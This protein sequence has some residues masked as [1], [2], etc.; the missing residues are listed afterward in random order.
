[1]GKI[2]KGLRFTQ[3]TNCAMDW[4]AGF[5]MPGCPGYPDKGLYAI[6]SVEDRINTSKIK[7]AFPTPT[8]CGGITQALSDLNDGLNY[9]ISI[10]KNG[11]LLQKIN[12]KMAKSVYSGKIAEYTDFY[13]KNCINSTAAQP[14]GSADPVLQ[15]ATPSGTSS[16]SAP[17]T[18]STGNGSVVNNIT[19][20][21][22]ATGTG[23]SAGSPAVSDTGVTGKLKSV[24][25]WAYW[26][27]GGL[28]VLTIGVIAL[29]GKGKTAA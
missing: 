26:G 28:V 23:T 12:A 21:G 16:G 27:L 10:E 22:S 15:T 5:D 24:P 4:Q 20:G 18:G 17:T 25:K 11:T 2:W 3:D 6:G 9:A 8:S 1:M 14:S 19:T 7:S 29:K 13:N